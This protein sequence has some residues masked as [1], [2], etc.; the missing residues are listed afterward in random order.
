[1]KL[2]S[3]FWQSYKEDPSDGEI[4]SHKL[5]VRAGLIQKSAAGLYNFLP[6]GW[7][8]VQKAI[9]IY[10]E[11]LNR[12]GAIELILPVMTPGELWRE[13]GRWDDMGPEMLKIQ[14]RHRRDLCA[15]P[16]NEEAMVDLF[17]RTVKSYKQLPL[18]LY[19]I[20]TKFR[21]EI[22]PRYGVMR[23]REFTMKD[24]YSFHENYECLERTYQ[25]MYACY[26]RIFSRMGLN[27]I[28]VEADAGAMADANSKTHE[29][30]VLANS[31]EDKII[32][33]PGSGYAANVERATTRPPS[34]SLAFNRRTEAPL[35]EVH[36]PGKKTIGDVC[37]FL[38]IPPHHCLK[39]LA[40]SAIAHDGHHDV[41]PNPNPNLNLL[42]FL[43]GDDQLNETKLKAHLKCAHLKAFSEDDFARL[44]LPKGFLGPHGLPSALQMRVIYDQA[45]D[46][47]AAY[48]IGAL[49]EDTH[50]MNF[51]PQRDR[52]GLEVADLRLS[53]AGDLSPSGGIVEEVRGIEV[54]HIFQL[55]DKYTKAMGV[56][57]LDRQGK[58]IFPLM[59]CYGTGPARTVAAAIEQHHDLKGIVWPVAIAPYQIHL[60]TIT[61]TADSE[62]KKTAD[63]IY[64]KL[65]EEN[66]EV[67]YDDREKVG[68]GFKL[69]DVELLGLPLALIFGERDFNRTGNVE[70]RVRRSQE[71]REYP[72]DDHLPAKIREL[73]GNLS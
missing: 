8:A 46:L 30:Q 3:G 42:I 51:I 1:M 36:T 53:R 26:E 33:C 13:S 48:T 52:D 32:R 59:G 57:V 29:F 64:R 73:L 18:N 28:V 50:Y 54:G 19:Q 43:L 71:K 15:S 68:A 2:S 58:G 38:N 65:L 5:M 70:V 56:T 7:R 9:A 69:K 62:A 60:V 24:A 6:L 39:A 14:D 17:R 4:P 20:N 10:R 63:A 23:S 12:S 21:D 47:T 67:F 35:E 22:R 61:K 49:K 55:G 31:G 37:A 40:Y 45:V 16:T 72:V 27:F 66:F 44:N 34:S 11:E 25:E 41:N